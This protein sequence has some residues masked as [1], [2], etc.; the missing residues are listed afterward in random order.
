MNNPIESNPI[1]KLIKF[2]TDDSKLNLHS[3]IVIYIHEKGGVE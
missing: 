1:F 2:L 3:K